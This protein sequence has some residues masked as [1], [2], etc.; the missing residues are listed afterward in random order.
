[1]FDTETNG[2]PEDW[3]APPSD[4]DNWPRLIQIAWQIH[5]VEG[6]LIEK[7][8]YIVQPNGFDIPNSD[9]HGITSARA[10][11]EGVELNQVLSMFA[12]AIGLANVVVAHN[13]PFDKNVVT[14]E[15]YRTGLKHGLLEKPG[16]CTMRESTEFCRI[17]QKRGP[18]KYKWPSLS[19]LHSTLFGEEFEGAHNAENDAAAC[20][21][22]FLEL[23]RR[24]V[25]PNPD[26]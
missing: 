23:K 3:S 1:M 8:G 12:E 22:C 16:V 9:I 21:K 19:E 15:F 17:P 14:A 11:R 13:L 24:G 6:D 25:I 7:Q 5:S 4:V 26:R 18:S 10:K 2:L 20:A